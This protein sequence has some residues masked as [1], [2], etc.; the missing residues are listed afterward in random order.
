ML[1]IYICYDV[2]SIDNHTATHVALPLCMTCVAIIWST[3]RF[4][5]LELMSKEM[6]SVIAFHVI[7]FHGERGYASTYI[8]IVPL[9]LA[10]HPR[11]Q[12][13]AIS[14]DSDHDIIALRVRACYKYTE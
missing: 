5:G 11:G 9:H 4:P 14:C 7:F 10:V 3:E 13:A 8:I 2:S 6:F 12:I 1:F